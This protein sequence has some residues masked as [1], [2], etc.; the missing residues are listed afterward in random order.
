MIK[1][2]QYPYCQF[3]FEEFNPVQEACYEYFIED[4]NLIVSTSMSS[5]KTAIAEAILSYELDKGGKVCYTSP[6]KALSYE[7]YEDWKE[8][9]EIGQHGIILLSGDNY[10]SNKEINKEKVVL[11]TVEALDVRVRKKSE[12]VNQLRCLIFDEAHLLGHDKRGADSEA[13][14]MGL[15]KLNPKCRII[16][17]SGTLANAKEIAKWLKKLNGK[18]TRFVK[19]DW[20]PCKIENK[21]DIY[22]SYNDQIL[23]VYENIN[24]NL[25]EK[26]LIFVHSKAFG[27]RLVKYLLDKNI[28]CAFYSSDLDAKRRQNIAK[29]F[30][31]KEGDLDV[32]VST[33]A[34]GMG[35]NL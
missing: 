18:T 6:L 1:T 34:L 11:S 16:F 27:R 24:E 29:R 26:S 4:C 25:L 10:V 15:T 14:I 17:L 32:L 19:S 5:G 30:K 8:K 33:S 31:D 35:I 13:L 9:K 12:W 7:K 21:I 2:K 28:S 20:R 3:D 23:K 22:G